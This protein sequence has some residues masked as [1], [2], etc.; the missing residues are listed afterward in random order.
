[1]ASDIRSMTMIS[2]EQEH[3]DRDME[4]SSTASVEDLRADRRELGAGL[5]GEMERARQ[6]VGELSG[7]QLVS[8]FQELAGSGAAWDEADQLAY[9]RMMGT[10]TVS[11]VVR[12]V[13]GRIRLSEREKNKRQNE[14]KKKSKVTES[15]RTSIMN[16]AEIRNREDVYAQDMKRTVDRMIVPDGGE[17][18]EGEE[19]EA[20]GR[21]TTEYFRASFER[22]D[23]MDISVRSLSNKELIER[24]PELIGDLDMA[25]GLLKYFNNQDDYAPFFPYSE[26][27]MEQLKKKAQGYDKQ[28][29]YLMAKMNILSSPYYG[30][31]RSEDIKDLSAGE[32]NERANACAEANQ[33]L[34]EYYRSLAIIKRLNLQAESKYIPGV[35]FDKA[36]KELLNAKNGGKIVR[37]SGDTKIESTAKARLFSLKV[38]HAL[39]AHA[40]ALSTEE[41][42]QNE[43]DNVSEDTYGSAD[44]QKAAEDEAL[45][46]LDKKSQ[47]DV[48]ASYSVTADFNVLELDVR[49]KRTFAGGSSL[50]GYMNSK[51]G[52]INATGKLAGSLFKEGTFRPQLVADGSVSASAIKSEIGG[53]A[54]LNLESWGKAGRNVLG[55]GGSLAGTVGSVFAKGSAKLGSWISKKG[56]RRTGLK[57]GGKTGANI[58]EG[59]ASASFTIFGLKVKLGVSAAV[60]VGANFG[61]KTTGTGGSLSIGGALGLGGGVK[62]SLDWSEMMKYF[63]KLKKKKWFFGLF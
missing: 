22:L 60:G 44:E 53:D 51:V 8:R 27:V 13:T 47:L 7:T 32:L 39:E 55:V 17:L 1:M 46:K 58:V 48:G 56:V 26:V 49:Q 57:F 31:L 50:T 63:D 25:V 40:G 42:E 20:L 35:L 34:A 33:G 12:E 16:A 3:R 5:P 6:P 61:V 2:E 21:Q 18:E 28:R 36:G 11:E 14:R 9:D 15:A 38:T 37:R 52:N 10:S 24:Y 4:A 41:I 59:K 19:R 29:D 43:R 45:K 62:I 23:A 30:L 54:K